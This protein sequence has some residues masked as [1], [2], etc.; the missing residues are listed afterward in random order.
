MGSPLNF[1]KVGFRNER[2]PRTLYGI[3]AAGLVATTLWHGMVLTRYLL[4]EREELDLK[5]QSMEEALAGLDADI[6]RTTAEL[7]SQ[8]NELMSQ[9]VEFLAGIYLQKGFSWT[10][11]FNQLEGIVP[12]DVRITSISP[13]AAQ[14]EVQV[15]MT[16]VGRSLEDLLEL[17]R[18]LEES[19]F[20]GTVMPVNEAH[21]QEG[22][23]V[24]ATI[25]LRYL[26]EEDEPPPQVE[27]VESEE[28][29]KPDDLDDPD[30]PAVE[31]DETAPDEAEAG[32]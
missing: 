31:D 17:V 15:S 24:A 18:T 27:S 9:R 32:L 29:E 10:E 5:V 1:A 21:Q 2:L 26:A 19:R 3:V 28:L 4:R 20:F 7:G 14:G 13:S 8:R 11:L 16:T 25:T 30:D 12:P 6:S 22:G 23:S